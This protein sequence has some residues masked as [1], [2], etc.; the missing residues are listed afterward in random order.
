MEVDEIIDSLLTDETPPTGGIS[1]TAIETGRRPSE[2][3]VP[4]GDSTSQDSDAP[5]SKHEQLAALVAGG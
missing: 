3:P 2:A 5:Q 1:A 4:T